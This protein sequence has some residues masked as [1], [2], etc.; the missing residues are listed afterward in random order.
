MLAVSALLIAAQQI[1][2]RYLERPMGDGDPILSNC[3]LE[4]APS[5]RGSLDAIR[6]QVWAMMAER[7]IPGLAVAVGVAGRIVYTEGFGYA[8]LSRKSPV[9]PDTQFRA[10]SV[11][12]LFT[13]AA[14]ARLVE[15]GGID[16]SAPVQ[17][18]VPLYPPKHG[19]I[20]PALLASHRAG[21]RPYRDDFEALNRTHFASVTDSLATFAADPLAA[22]PGTRF[23]YSNYGY[24]LLSAAIEGA[25]RVPFL[26]YVH[27]EVFRPLGMTATVPD[28][29]GRDIPARATTYDVETPFSLDGTMVPSPPNDFS[30][31]WASGGFLSTVTDLVRFGS[32]FISTG[33]AQTH[34]LA[35][36][37]ISL[38]TK[39]RSGLPPFAGYGLGWMTASDL[40]GRRVYFH[41]GASS[42]GTAVLAVYP[43]SGVVVAAMANLGHAKFPFRALINVVRPFLPW[44][45]PDV[46]MIA[47]AIFTLAVYRFKPRT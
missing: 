34:F 30:S 35:S 25:A 42:G 9:C 3:G 39:P 40:H 12:K 37:T 20:T 23:I 43:G 14:L 7:R 1:G 32:A 22:E 28:A 8:D 29:I 10:G 19:R 18:Y 4:V 5:Y 24:V 11:S 6:Q 47:A 21:V 2:A 15:R 26:D 36:D 17:R 41:F 13:S 31:K 27:A 16:L 33:P 45:S 44:Y 46:V 38:L